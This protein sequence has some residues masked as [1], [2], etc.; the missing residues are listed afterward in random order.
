M[1]RTSLWLAALLAGACARRDE[2]PP[3]FA[4]RVVAHRL[5]RV[6]YDNTVRD[7][8]ATSQRPGA[9]TFPADDF[10]LGF[11]TIAEV[12]SISPLHVELY[13]QAADAILDELFGEGTLPV[14]TWRFEAESSD[15][16]A[17]LGNVWDVGAWVLWANG[18]LRAT[19]WLPLQADYTV[20]VDVAGQ[21]A[22]DALVRAAIRVDGGE[23]AAF[24]VVTEAG[25]GTERHEVRLPL[26]A[27]AHV[28]EVA[29]LN[30][31]KAP[32][33][34]RNLIVDRIE[35][36]GPLDVARTRSPAFGAV[37]PCDGA[38]GAGQDAS[39]AEGACAERVAREL[40]RR[41]LRRP[42]TEVEV[43]A[44]MRHYAEVREAGGSYDEGLRGLI[45]GL[46][47]SPSF[48]YRV[49]PD[50]LGPGAGGQRALNG[51]ELASRLSYFV[52]SSTP[53]DR[54][55]DLAQ[56]GALVDPG[57]LAAETRRML[58]DPRA[59]ALVDNLG[60][61]WLGVRKVDEAAPSASVFPDWD[62]GLQASLQEELRRYVRSILRADRSALELVTSDETWVDARLAAFYGVA[63]PSDAGSFEPVRI[64]DRP[65]LLTR[66]GLLAALAYPTRT[67]PVVRGNWVLGNLL[68][69]APPPPPG[70]ITPLSD[71]PD[72]PMSLRDQ[73]AA[74][75]ADPA[76]A[77]C[78]A[79]MDPVG[80]ALEE[81]DAIGRY[82]EEDEF[83][84]PI[85]AT[86]E[87]SG[88]GTFDGAAQMQALLARDP[89]LP[90]CMVTKVL[91][92]ALGR[93]PT[94]ADAQTEAELLQRFAASGYRFEALVTDVVLSRPFRW[95]DPEALVEGPHPEAP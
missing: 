91:T 61:Q 92:Y 66:A 95:R 62:S 35:V 72:T 90:Q 17:D 65:G 53:D 25:Q 23:V 82:R 69:A 63:G 89:R 52:W 30:E 16:T 15:V 81:Y 88:L 87:L 76:C 4:G 75:R 67:S 60:G 40:G 57:V 85:D 93:G 10:G 54:L 29:Y 80:L 68:C 14:T 13:D 70:G 7:L 5:N 11:D 19:A 34:D 36:A 28:V 39:S 12:L 78:H 27:G 26:A 3:P 73:L 56:S 58:A 41:I 2:P 71:T 45:K 83:G 38:P 22:G 6:E 47:L 46:L 49:E 59:D 74:H 24:D 18:G 9:T 94:D 64:P 50:P 84:F 77:G 37:I 86:G 51:F 31:Y 79:Q 20:A 42:L 8:F 43:T 32:P 33:D 1:S 21:Q 48:V 44:K 55:L